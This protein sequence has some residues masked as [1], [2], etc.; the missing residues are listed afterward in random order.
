MQTALLV[1]VAPQVQLGQH[2]LPRGV[3][4]TLNPREGVWCTGDQGGK[5]SR[6]RKRLCK[7]SETGKLGVWG[8]VS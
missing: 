1:F 5:C 4:P 7:G 3:M 8:C 2:R 6:L